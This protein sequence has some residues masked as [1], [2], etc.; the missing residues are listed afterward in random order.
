MPIVKIAGG[1]AV[2]LLAVVIVFQLALA[3]GAPF[4]KAA[5]GGQHEKVLPTRL[6]IAS[7]AVAFLI[8]PLI[9]V[10]VLGFAG[11]IEVGFLPENGGRLMWVLAGV[12]TL[13]GIAN[14]VSRSK[15]ERFWALVSVSIA[16]CC[17]VIASAV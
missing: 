14:L 2:L 7:A 4:G 3:L 9:V 8:Y 12:F 17:A 15:V 10:A 1:I 11:L 13:G 6:R 5:W 16:I